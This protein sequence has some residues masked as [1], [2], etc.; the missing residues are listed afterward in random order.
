MKK[1]GTLL[2]LLLIA[3]CVSSVFGK[4]GS[5]NIDTCKTQINVALSET[6]TATPAISAFLNLATVPPDMIIEVDKT[7]P[8]GSGPWLPAVF[9]PS[10]VLKT[11]LYRARDTVSGYSCT[12]QVKIQDG[13]PP[14]L[15]CGENVAVSVLFGI[16]TPAFLRDS[17]GFANAVSTAA[18]ACGGA[19]NLTYVDNYQVYPCDSAFSGII[20]RTWRAIDA[21]GNLGTCQQKIKL[22][23]HTLDEIVFPIDSIGSCPNGGTAPEFTGLPYIITNNHVFYSGTVFG[24]LGVGY[25][26]SLDNSCGDVL[27]RK[28]LALDWCAFVVRE[29]VQQVFTTNPTPSILECPE[30]LFINVAADNNCQGLIILPDFAVTQPC[31]AI[32]SAIAVWNNGT[33]IDTLHF[34]LPS[35]VLD[36]GIIQPVFA[37]TL[38]GFP[39]G[40]TVV[41]YE[42]SDACGNIAVCSFQVYL[43]DTTGVCSEPPSSVFCLARTETLQPIEE[44]AVQLVAPAIPLNVTEITDE[45]GTVQFPP[46]PVNTEFGLGLLKNNSHANGVTTADLIGISRHILGIQPLG[47]PYKLIAADANRSGSITTFDIVTV[48]SLILGITDEFPNNTSW[49]FLPADFV[50][51]NPA[52][53][54]MGN[55]PAITYTTPVLDPIEFIGI[56]VGDVNNT[57]DPLDLTIFDERDLRTLFF[58]TPDKQVKEGEEFIAT[59]S[60]TERAEGF[61]FTLNADNLDILEV[62][63]GAGVNAE[64]FALFPSKNTLTVAC[65]TAGQARFA[66][67]MR[68][69]RSGELH[70]M[71]R[72]GS[73][74]THAEAYLRTG[75]HLET[76][77]VELRFPNAGGDFQ[78]H[79]NQPNPAG[80]Y[81]DISFNLPAET[82]ATLTIMDANGQVVHSK[83]GTYTKGIQTIRVDLTGV[84]PGVLYYQVQT[85]GNCAVRKM[86]KG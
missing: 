23:E 15:T 28:W 69:R 31:S 20:T 6:C 45:T 25:T 11:Y 48:R 9:G 29:Q 61:Q 79:Q 70:D 3:L 34:P 47:S 46:L 5:V 72:I 35:N 73:N 68:S 62:L 67:R 60:S 12:G 8:Y 51:P 43:T 66:V 82:E 74:V 55:M 57:A 7:L 76:A 32:Q 56:K 18:D 14:V 2:P 27:Y 71:L 65:E 86:V 1:I 36:N 30:P 52:N 78:L 80:A 58:E 85:A 44:V 22:E 49:R 41:R 53:P 64:Q 19:V 42:V 17:L 77:K 39:M 40:N 37:D 83:S 16:R 81:T 26:D 59:I 10:D 4:T 75:N 50:F 13:L 54:F 63:P 24:R 33:A 38:V 21:S 84:A